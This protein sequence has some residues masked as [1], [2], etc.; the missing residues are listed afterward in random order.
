MPREFKNNMNRKIK[1]EINTKITPHYIVVIIIA[2]AGF[3][4]Y[5]NSIIKGIFIWDD[6]FLVINNPVIKDFSHIKDIFTTHLFYGGKAYSN[7]YRPLQSLSFMIDYHFW[8]FNPFGYHLINVI[9]HILNSVMAYFLVYLISKKRDVSIFTGLLFCVHTVFSGP[10]NYISA[11]ADLLNTFFFLI[12]M[13]SYVLYKEGYF[14]GYGFLIYLSSL[15]TFLLALLS[16]EIACIVPL[17]FLFYLFCFSNEKMRL[18]KSRRNLIWVFFII[19]AIYGYLR[20]TVLSFTEGKLIETT[21]AAI[22]LYNRL[23]TASKVIMV[24]LRILLIPTGLH[25]ERYIEPARSFMQDE[26]FLSMVGLFIIGCFS[27]FFYKTSKIKFFFIGWFFIWLVPYSNIYPLPYFIGEG[28]LYIP[29]IGFF[30]LV[31]MYL[32]ELSK[33]SKIWLYV[34]NV[35]LFFL[36]VFYGSLTIK[37]AEKWSDPVKLWSNTAKYSPKS[38]KA[39]LELG[40]ALAKKGLYQDAENQ[41]QKA[42]ELNPRDYAGYNNIGNIYKVKGDFKKAEEAYKKAIELNPKN[43]NSYS[44]LGN[45]YLQANRYDEAIDC[46]KKAIELNPYMANF[47]KN[48][49]IAYKS[50]GMI[51]EGEASFKKAIELNPNL[52]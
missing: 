13:I 15:S 4:V 24:Y 19:I 32:S 5:Y 39:H 31:A 52:K 46:Y 28:Y 41:M 7:F 6:N 23:L 1:K 25:I 36:I 40:V 29:S 21:T 34:V 38:Y 45:I 43:A 9:T 2:I 20:F 12:S 51:Q 48:L 35:M 44:N 27:Y 18:E 42:L 30:A 16:K 3:I 37:E 26:V 33:K 11:R 14:K 10:V 49:S 8:K 47:Y 22:P 50:K 17:I